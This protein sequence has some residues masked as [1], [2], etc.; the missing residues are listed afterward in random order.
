MR[1]ILRS[2]GSGVVKAVSEAVAESAFGKLVLEVVARAVAQ[3]KADINSPSPGCW[4]IAF[5]KAEAIAI[6]KATITGVSQGFAGVLT[7]DTLLKAQ[8]AVSNV[9]QDIEVAIERVALRLEDGSGGGRDSKTKTAVAEARA[10]AINCAIAQAFAGIADGV[11]EAEVL[12]Q[13]GCPSD[14]PT[15][16]FIAPAMLEVPSD[17]NCLQVSSQGAPSLCGKW[18]DQQNGDN[19]CYV[20]SSC[21][22]A[23]DSLQYS[24][25]KWRYCSNTLQTMKNWLDFEDDTN[26][27]SIRQGEFGYCPE[28]NPDDD[29]MGTV[30]PP[31]S[32]TYPTLQQCPLFSCIGDARDCCANPGGTCNTR[33]GTS[34]SYVGRCQNGKHVW[35][36]GIIQ[37]ACN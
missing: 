5:G 21:M 33:F 26:E 12:V 37:C 22:C 30:R 2:G 7:G 11:S 16:A 31:T 19:I 18:G 1:S 25:L 29:M 3:V 35:D 17:C 36:D 4:A 23:Q 20:P 10:V 8:A 28:M 14:L 24:G 6:A 9:E 13:V 15:A 34:Y 32:G 27:I